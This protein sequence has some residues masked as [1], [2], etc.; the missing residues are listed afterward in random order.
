MR[1]GVIAVLALAIAA[2][3]V[4]GLLWA[5]TQRALAQPIAFNH[6][7]HVKEVGSGCLDCHPHAADGVRATIPNVETCAACHGEPQGHSHEEARLVEYVKKKEP[8][9]WREVY[10]LPE[11]V[12]FSHRRHTRLGG[13]TCAT[14]HGEVTEQVRPITQPFRRPT[15]EG[16]I[17]CHRETGARN[18]CVACHR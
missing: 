16:C 4:T 7:L 2:L 8:I 9:L 6:R 18:D 10:W 17:G 3:V 11:H 14:C 13:L 12:Y 15:M 5:A 1:W